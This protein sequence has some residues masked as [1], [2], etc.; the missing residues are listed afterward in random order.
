VDISELL[1]SLVSADRASAIERAWSEAGGAGLRARKDQT[2]Y[3]EDDPGDTVYVLL[4]GHLVA[5]NTPDDELSRE[6]ATLLL[7]A[8]AVIGDR[9]VVAGISCQ[10]TVACL[11]PC[12]LVVCPRDRFLAAW[13]EPDF[14]TLVSLDLLRRYASHM[15]MASLQRREISRRLQFVIPGLLASELRDRAF[16]VPLLAKLVRAHTKTVQRGLRA[17]R[18]EG[19]LDAPPSPALVLPLFHALGR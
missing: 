14:R 13:E 16:E 17:L 8:P 7:E 12:K 15:Q 11:S 10:E 4:E 3:F 2:L 9:E 18:A 1:T 19:A 5:F 6:Q